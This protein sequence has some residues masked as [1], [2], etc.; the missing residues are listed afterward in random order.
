MVIKIDILI[1]V[2][3]VF[4]FGCTQK[5]AKDEHKRP[6][7]VPLST[8]WKGGND[9]GQWYK[10]SDIDSIR[11]T[12]HFIIYNDYDGSI[13]SNKTFI[14]NCSRNIPFH[15]QKIPD[16]IEGYDGKRILLNQISLDKTWCYFE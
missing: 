6:K 15:W 13:E 4:I 3:F 7:G 2:V 5:Q 10:I 16:Y 14:L 12:A 8:F 11:E 1:V 9:G